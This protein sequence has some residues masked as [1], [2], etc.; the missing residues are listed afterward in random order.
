MFLLPLQ[1]CWLGFKFIKQEKWP[2]LPI[3][4]YKSMISEYEVFI[5]LWV[6]YHMYTK[7]NLKIKRNSRVGKMVQQCQLLF[8]RTRVNSQHPHGI[9]LPSAAPASGTQCT[10]IHRQNTYT[11]KSKNQNKSVVL[12]HNFSSSTQEVRQVDLCSR[13]DQS[14][15]RAP[16][17][18]GF[19]RDRLIKLKQAKKNQ[20]NIR[21]LS[22]IKKTNTYGLN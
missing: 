18:P 20:D 13:P 17:Q 10:D 7:L 22:S 4:N 5:F 8:Q 3:V 12:A 16:G 2:V 1:M 15:Q 6:Q 21:I 19:Y 11:H 9:Y 14:T